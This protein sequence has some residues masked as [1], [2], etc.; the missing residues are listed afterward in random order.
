MGTAKPTAQVDGQA[1]SLTFDRSRGNYLRGIDSCSIR[2][3]GAGRFPGRMG[4]CS[5]R[6]RRLLCLQRGP[7]PSRLFGRHGVLNWLIAG[8]RRRW[9][10]LPISANEQLIDAALKIACRCRLGGRRAAGRHFIGRA[11]R[12]RWL[13]SVNANPRRP[14]RRRGERS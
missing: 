5:E 4:S 6:V 11:R 10:F 8:F 9:R 14:A 2:R 3:S 1:R 13:S 7:A 12:N